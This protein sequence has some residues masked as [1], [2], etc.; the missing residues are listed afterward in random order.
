MTKQRNGCDLTKWYIRKLG[1]TWLV[2]PP[3]IVEIPDWHKLAATF[4]TG[5]E[6]HAAFAR[7]GQR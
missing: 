2:M 3:V 7:G 1:S 6:A 4:T 5:T